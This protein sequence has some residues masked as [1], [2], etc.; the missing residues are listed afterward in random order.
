MYDIYLFGVCPGFTIIITSTI[1]R[2]FGKS[3]NYQ[4]CNF[5]KSLLASC[6]SITLAIQSSLKLKISFSLIEDLYRG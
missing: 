4:V 1:S 3:E 6:F 5:D 2:T